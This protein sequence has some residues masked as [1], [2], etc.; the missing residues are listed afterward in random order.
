MKWLHISDIHFNFKGYESSTV[1]NKLLS[2]LKDLNTSVDFILITGDCLYKY[3]SDGIDS[4]KII[5]YI[6]EIARSCNCP[7]NRVYFC[8][9]NHDLDRENVERNDKIDKIRKKK[10]SF[11]DSYN[12]LNTGANDRFQMI[13]KGVTNRTYTSY[14]IFAPK[15]SNYRI[16]SLNS[17]LLSKD[18]KDVGHLQICCDKLIDM[19]SQIRND[20]R[21]NILIMHH[22]VDC[23]EK[24]DSVQFQHWMED[25]HID[26]V[27][28]GHTHRSSVESYAET[29]VDLKQFTAGAIIID[30]YA[31]PSFYL[32][33]YEYG[34]ELISR[35]FTYSK[36]AEIWGL[37]SHSLRKFKHGIFSYKLNRMTL[38]LSSYKDFIKRMNK[39][40][41][42]KFHS[43]D[44]VSSNMEGK[45]EF[46][47][48]KIISSLSN[49][50]MPYEK[51][52]D[53]TFQVMMQITDSNFQISGS[54]LSCTELKKVIYEKIISQKPSVDEKEYII[55]CWASRYARRYNRH[56]EMIIQ[57]QNG[58]TEK[59]NYS[60]VQ[61][62]LLKYIFDDVTG[63]EIFYLKTSRNELQRMSERI[64]EFL[65]N[66]GIF[67][68]RETALFSLVKEYMTQKPHPW[69]VNNKEQVV[70]YNKEQAEEHIKRLA[71]HE[72][73]LILQTEAAYHICAIF[74]AM[75][76]KVIGCT[77]T[78]PI[79]A[80]K[81][82]IN[83]M[84]NNEN[85]ILNKMPMQKYQVFQ[86]KKD[87]ENLDINFS[88]FTEAVNV[89]YDYIIRR[90]EVTNEKTASALI[91][92]WN[93]IR[94]LEQKATYDNKLYL[95]H[96]LKRLQYI[97]EGGTGFIVKSPLK[98][99]NSCFWFEPNWEE[100]ETKQ[101]HLGS[102]ILVC[103]IKSIDCVNSIFDYL[104]NNRSFKTCKNSEL[105]FVYDNYTHFSK[106]DRNTIRNV[107]KGKSI[108]CIFIQEENFSDITKDNNWRNI[109]FDIIRISKIS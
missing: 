54:T 36:E 73:V 92:L 85:F 57:M 37:D 88:R 106:E 108:K 102:Q 45:E 30:D 32:C 40:Y 81:I 109:L 75:Y 95:E 61:G 3:G 78:S 49:I 66:I 80:L 35:L 55:S 50:S 17:C 23:L 94:K 71:D 6:R 12:Q 76:D 14:Q 62:S 97:F 104:Y 51:A 91:N 5:S 26:V 69:L 99:L 46:D 64:L 10:K 82:A 86:L 19:E 59:I 20:N 83:G 18:K 16:I 44:I 67:E 1:R 72:K 13:V 101:Q 25:H 89:V 47:V 56:S 38:D 8:Q 41:L 93:I 24:K 43:K 79:I 90:Q 103:I 63:N 65:R 77:E 34:G 9:G 42:D 28:C 87:L 33:E 4:E 7:N 11:S 22:G 31:I 48:S 70:S 68:I 98:G 100:Y 21:I 2:A 39:M 53:I 105:I 60:Y 58:K 96:P 74:L 29:G 52:L 84:N 15:N 107:F 27:F